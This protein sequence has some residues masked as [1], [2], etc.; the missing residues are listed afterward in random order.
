MTCGQ[1]LCMIGGLK[2]VGVPKFTTPLETSFIGY[3]FGCSLYNFIQRKLPFMHFAYFYF[4]EFASMHRGA[5]RIIGS[6]KFLKVCTEFK[7]STSGFNALS[8]KSWIFR[9]FKN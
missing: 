3:R 6:S 2:K 7:P 4:L 9:S 1:M 8:L 5:G